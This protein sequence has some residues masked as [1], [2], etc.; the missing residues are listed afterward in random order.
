VVYC[1]ADRL[2]LSNDLM[3]KRDRPLKWRLSPDHCGIQIACR[4]G[5]WPHERFAC[6]LQLRLRRIPPLQLAWF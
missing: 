1:F 4:N 2:D 3:P 5:Y 6:P